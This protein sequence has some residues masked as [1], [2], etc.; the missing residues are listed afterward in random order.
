M[1]RVL[2]IGATGVFGSRIAKLLSQDSG[3]EL[4][5]AGRT[6]ESLEQLQTQL[7]GTS[8]HRRYGEQI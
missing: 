2:L 4:I 5:L 6:R 1:I 8:K 3:I 7:L